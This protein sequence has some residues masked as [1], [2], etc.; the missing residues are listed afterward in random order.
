M[1]GT[2]EA[3]VTRVLSRD[4]T[5]IGYWTTGEGPPLVLVHGAVADH[6]RWR[7][8][9]PYLEPHARVHALDRRGRGASG[10]APAYDLAREFED[11]A[12]VV[13]AVAEASGSTVD[14]YGHSFGGL[15]AF[16]GATLSANVGRLVLYE[17][18][19]PVDPGRRELPP[20]VGERLEALLV[21]GDRDAVVETMFREVV[22]MP[23]AEITALRAQP[24]WPARVAA[25]PTIVRELR[26]IP[27]APF[28]PWQA[29]RIAAPTLLLTGSDSRDPFAA[30]TAT[31]AAALPDARVG[32]PGGPAARGR[33]P[34]PRAGR[35]PPARVPARPA[36]MAADRFCVRSADGTPLAVW[37]GG[38]G[39]PLVLVHG[40]MCD[41][42]AFDPL[43]AELGGTMTTFAMDRRG[44]GASG[45]AAGYAI[46][47]EFE[48][49]AA[50]VA[51]VADRTGGPV[52][53]WGHSYGAGCAMGGAALTGDVHHLVLYEPGLGI[54]YPPGAIEEVEAAVAG[55]RGGGVW[56]GGE[57]EMGWGEEGRGEDGWVYRPGA[58]DAVAAPT[59]LLAGSESPP[60][61]REATDLAAAAIPDARVRVLDGHAHL[62]IRT[63][64][65][66]VA[67]VIGRF[68]SG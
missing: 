24:A 10:D 66:M 42:T 13:D 57:G 41:H 23:E 39:P 30:D 36:L 16:G 27:G 12:A 51:E 29:A 50:V 25:A 43:V 46:E 4:G 64:P 67:A 33:H 7:P 31:V 38:D 1:A 47:R 32:G 48:D 65:A 6:H 59:L 68:V 52:A 26:A 56:D 3:T 18:W 28:D 40:S 11:V 2:A 44:F 5:E 45:D 14:L 17:G 21:A 35:R 54:P 15:C 20:G 22:R 9:L 8:L 34:R 60:V 58:F 61:L 55:G 62:A 53:L 19:P 63:D 37:V 49:V